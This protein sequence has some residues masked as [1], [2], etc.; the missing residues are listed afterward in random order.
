P[1]PAPAADG[2]PAA[3]GFQIFSSAAP[4]AD[5]TAW[6][7]HATGK[8]SKQ[9]ASLAQ[10]SPEKLPIAEIQQRCREEF[11]AAEFYQKARE[12][13]LELGERFRWIEYVWRRDGEALCRMRMPE[14]GDD[15]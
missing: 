4:E 5:Q 12:A 15:L 9:E 10:S 14:A 2:T 11:S 1:E 3:A 6:V 13:E 8:L 7:L